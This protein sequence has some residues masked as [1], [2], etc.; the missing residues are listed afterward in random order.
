MEE[1]IGK[2]TPLEMHPMQKG[3][4]NITYA[5]TVRLEKEINYKPKTDFKEGIGRFVEWWKNYS[6]L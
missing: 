4:V 5:D 2:D 6:E 1:E 3:D